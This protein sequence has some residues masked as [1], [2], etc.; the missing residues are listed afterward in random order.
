MGRPLRLKFS[1]KNVDEAGVEQE[2]DLSEGPQQ[3]P[4]EGSQQE[5]PEGQQKEL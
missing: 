1:Q 2:E 4:S 5:A 3:E